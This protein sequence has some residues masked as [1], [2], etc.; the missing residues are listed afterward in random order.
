MDRRDFLKLAGLAGLTVATPARW[1]FAQSSEGNS[2]PLYLVVH[3]GGGW[4]PTSL[5]DPKGADDPE[6]PDRMNN[7]LKDDIRSPSASSPIRWAPF[8][9]N[10]AFFER[11]YD[12]LLILNGINTATNSHDAGPRHIHSGQLEE[13]HPAFT[14]LVAAAFARDKPMGFITN[15]GYDLTQGIV[16][17]TRV[18]S[19]DA[20]QRIA[21]P[22]QLG[23]ES[24]H[25]ETTFERINAARAARLQRKIAAQNLPRLK[26]SLGTLE[27]ARTGN[28]ELKALTEFMPDLN[29]FATGLG[30]QAALAM[31]AWRAGICVSANLATGGFDTHGNHDQNHATALARLT[32]GLNEIWAE[33]ERLGIED[34]IT[35]VVGSDF[36][37]TPGYNE[38]NGKDH[39]SITSMMF[40]GHGIRGNRVIGASTDRHRAINIDPTSFAP[41]DSG[42]LTL[43]PVHVQRALR[44]LAGIDQ[45]DL[46]A[47]FPIGGEDLDL[48]G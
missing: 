3:A 26:N 36:G 25:T 35:I 5:C 18:G 45:H 7:Y 34:S 1:G 16:A 20:I 32:D 37:R 11:H 8:A 24:F 14:A 21:Q 29:L 9:N 38:G 2:G 12:K 28:N 15:G 41:T 6:L 31:A 47:R 42:G 19:I 40:M 4:D 39:W 30:R 46:S 23:E 10:D 27:L 17:R 33:A 13:G 22:N 44:K 43:S 48:F